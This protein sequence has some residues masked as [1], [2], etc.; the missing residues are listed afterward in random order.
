MATKYTG[1][2][3]LVS[4]ESLHAWE[5]LGLGYLAS[6]SYKFGYAREQ[7]RFYNAEFDSSDTIVDGCG[8][9][10][11]VAFSLTTFQIPAAWRYSQAMPALMPYRC[12]VFCPRSKPACG[13]STPSP[14]IGRFVQVASGLPK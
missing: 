5:C 1:P 6:Y 12:P 2:I 13:T 10:E 7:Y 11:V 8:D 9:A 14:A 4:P 3:A